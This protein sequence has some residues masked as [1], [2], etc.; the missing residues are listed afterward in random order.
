MS[1]IFG[2]IYFDGRSIRQETLDAMHSVMSRW[3]P[4]GTYTWHKGSAGL[5]FASLAITPESGYEAMPLYDAERDIALVAAARLDNRDELC[6]I[7]GIPLADRPTTPDGQLVMRAFEK[8]EEGC[9]RHLYGDWSYAAW[10]SRQRKLIL[11]RDHLGNRGLYYSHQPPLFA[12]ASSPE[13]LFAF[14][15]IQRQINELKLAR[16]ITIFSIEDDS[17]TIWQGVHTL[18]PAR[19]L[20]V[21]PKGTQIR[22]YWCVE[23]LPPVNPR[24]DEECLEG[25]L[26]RYRAAVRACPRSGPQKCSNGNTCHF[27]CSSSSCRRQQRRRRFHRFW[28]SLSRQ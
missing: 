6:D 2:L 23:N 24:S 16:Y 27:Q 28:I 26:H 12:F 15:E 9:P 19:S 8:W 11:A 22:H 10:D 25:F 7:F 5:G 14:G 17:E 1:A 21:T 4:N 20:V 13:P 18:L 3:G